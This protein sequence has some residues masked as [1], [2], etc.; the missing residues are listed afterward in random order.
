MNSNRT[1][2]GSERKKD[3]FVWK[4]LLRIFQ[5]Y[6]TRL[7]YIFN[8]LNILNVWRTRVLVDVLFNDTQGMVFDA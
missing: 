8:I 5:L 2:K 7:F 6:S 1:F 4:K 3:L